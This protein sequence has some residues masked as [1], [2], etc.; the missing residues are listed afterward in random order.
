M[1]K[2]TSQLVIHM[3][4]IRLILTI[5]CLYSSAAS[6]ETIG[7]SMANM[8]KFQTALA[9]GIT[10]HGAKIPGVK[11]TMESAGGDAAKQMETVK[12]FVADK[13]DALIV[14]PAD[15]DMGAELSKIASDAKIPLV[16]VN[17]EPANLAELP[18]K[19]TLVAS[20]EK[21]SGT[22]QTKEVCRQLHGKGNVV[23]LMG[24][25]FMRRLASG[26]KM[27]PK[28]W[29]RMTASRSM[30]SSGRRQTGRR[31]LPNFKCRNG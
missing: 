27:L 3:C 21:D 18:E 10:D 31:S 15:G 16:Y 23:I 14:G 4:K 24:S 7:V 29:R 6:A 1:R 20:D 28:C 25:C 22:L 13:V 12:K 19:Q 9:A 26:R 30:S 8:D 2:R 11:I 17:N 5:A